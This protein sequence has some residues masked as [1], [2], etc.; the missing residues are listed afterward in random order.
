MKYIHFIC[1]NGYCGCDEDFYEEFED[2]ITDEEIEKIADDIIHESYSW[3]NDTEDF[4][5]DA[6]DFET[7]EEYL[8]SVAWYQEDCTIDWEEITEEEYLEN[9]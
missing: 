5:A 2:N 3:Y 7:E 9:R 1:S 8:E 6:D 4:V